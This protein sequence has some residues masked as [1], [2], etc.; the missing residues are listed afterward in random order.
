MRCWVGD[1][2]CWELSNIDWSKLTTTK[3]VSRNKKKKKKIQGISYKRDFKSIRV[4]SYHYFHFSQPCEVKLWVSEYTGDRVLELTLN[5]LSNIHAFR[6]HWKLE[7]YAIVY[8][9]LLNPFLRRITSCPCPT[10]HIICFLC[11]SH[12]K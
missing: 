12:G 11:L 10:A 2:V 6:S 5:T 1:P 8:D 9:L 3:V 7:N 4:S